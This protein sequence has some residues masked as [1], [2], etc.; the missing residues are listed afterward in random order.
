MT[1]RSVDSRA[2]RRIHSRSRLVFDF[3]RGRTR[4]AVRDLGAPLRVMHGFELPDG[5]LLVQIVSAAPGLFA[6]DRYELEIEAKDGARAVVL[7]PA[8]TKIHSM[9]NGGSARQTVRAAVAADASLEIYPTLSIPF[10]ESDFRQDVEV[11]LSEGARFGWMDPWAFGRIDSGEKYAFRRLTTRLRIDRGGAPLYR[12]AMDL[13][14]GEM[15]ISGYGLLEGATH[16]VSGCWFGPGDPWTPKGSIDDRLALGRVGADGLYARGLFP[17]GASFR[18]ALEE[19]RRRVS[20]AWQL[21]DFPQA[22][23]TL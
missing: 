20:A 5:R 2:A 4:L 18:Q 19:I 22:Q 8:A 10:P 7:T 23:F 14:P 17:D 6:G 3:A 12:D 15:D 1:A 9:P 21:A 13:R 16:A 11:A